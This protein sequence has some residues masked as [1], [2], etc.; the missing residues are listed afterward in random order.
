[1]RACSVS[2]RSWLVMATKLRSRSPSRARICWSA[3]ARRCERITWSSTSSTPILPSARLRARSL[4]ALSWLSM[5][6]VAVLNRPISSSPETAP[7]TRR[8]SRSPSAMPSSTRVTSDSGANARLAHT[9]TRMPAMATTSA[10]QF[11]GTVTI[12]WSAIKAMTAT[13][14]STP[15]GTAILIQSFSM[16]AVRFIPSVCANRATRRSQ[17]SGRCRTR[18]RARPANSWR[19]SRARPGYSTASKSETRAPRRS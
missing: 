18:R 9:I 19:S 1:M 3:S 14:A 7:A 16:T 4:S 12:H 13:N 11:L 8:W 2:R 6:L 15:T 10:N 5:R 17:R